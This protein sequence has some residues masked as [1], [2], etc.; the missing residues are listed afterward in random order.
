MPKKF[1]SGPKQLEK[2]NLPFVFMAL[3]SRKLDLT[4]LTKYGPI[5]MHNNSRHLASEDVEKAN[6]H[7]LAFLTI[8]IIHIAPQ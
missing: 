2:H 5:D 1:L 8:H 4:A 7:H 6:P 3:S